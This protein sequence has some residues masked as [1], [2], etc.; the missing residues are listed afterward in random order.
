MRI[1]ALLTLMAVI[2]LLIAVPLCAA[3]DFTLSE[4]WDFGP[5]EMYSLH[6]IG[7]DRFVSVGLQSVSV[8]SAS[9]T[10]LQRVQV[11][12]SAATY[13]TINPSSMAGNRFYVLTLLGGV[14]VFEVAA[15]YSVS[16]VG[17]IPLT[18]YEDS[19]LTQY[20]YI[21]MSGNFLWTDGIRM[22]VGRE[23]FSSSIHTPGRYILDIYD[24]GTGQ[25]LTRHQ[26]HEPNIVI[27]IHPLDEG[28]YITTHNGMIYY[29]DDLCELD[30]MGELASYDIPYL[31]RSFVYQ[32]KLHVMFDLDY[33]R[34]AR[35][36]CQPDHHLSRDWLITAEGVY[37]TTVIAVQDERFTFIGHDFTT[38]LVKSYTTTG[39]HW[40]GEPVRA[41]K[42]LTLLPLGNGYLGGNQDK[43]EFYSHNFTYLRTLMEHPRQRLTRL[44][45]GRWAICYGSYQPNGYP[46]RVYDLQERRWLDH[47]LRIRYDSGSFRQDTDN[48][49]FVYDNRVQSI[50]FYPD[51]SQRVL[52][53]V[54]P[55]VNMSVDRW[56]DRVALVQLRMGSYV[57]S[58]CDVF[59]GTLEELGSL[60][61]G[62]SPVPSV[63]FYGPDHLVLS[64]ELVTGH[65]LDFYRVEPDGFIKR[66]GQF[67]TDVYGFLHCSGS[68][69][70]YGGTQGL[71]IDVSNPDAPAVISLIDP[72]RMRIDPRL[73]TGDGEG[74][75]LMAD[76]YNRYSHILDADFV[77][78]ESFAG[79][80]AVYRG[81]RRILLQGYNCLV[82]VTHPSYV[83]LSDP[84]APAVANPLGLPYPNPFRESVK[85]DLELSAA[86]NT[87]VDVYNIKGQKVRC[88]L[89][90]RL[91]KGKHTLEWDGRDDA[92]AK[93]S[94]GIYVLRMHCGEMQ[95]TR[96]MVLIK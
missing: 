57:L 71:A 43:T 31:I 33:A 51:D 2:G 8:F 59:G 96:R 15:D 74:H 76:Y 54:T 4:V 20:G 49:S 90:S 10:S 75:Y 7:G 83:P 56:A 89:S 37:P 55:D 73:V 9:E 47:A 17:Y 91:G 77:P 30:L 35:Y 61:L 29:T 22:A 53:C 26:H 41:W 23:T 16:R 63:L 38:Y 88:I 27:G 21:P 93:V 85:L 69:I 82:E 81:G 72:L 86:A 68:T 70:L 28:F 11:F 50:R 13:T 94:A 25:L 87:R 78:V 32:G 67:H 95:H 92:G 36:T 44:I 64:R 3:P 66:V 14:D 19:P 12:H 5:S 79:E 52:D 39:E 84:I 80:M 58:V 45:Q 6:P 24:V 1:S 42:G 65:R 40:A 34:I 46:L 48:Y 62:T 18:P 60:A